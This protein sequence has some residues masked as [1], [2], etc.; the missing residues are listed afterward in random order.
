MT[1][2]DS[3]APRV[4][5][6]YGSGPSNVLLISYLFPPSSGVGSPRALSYTR[7]LPEH[8]CRVVVLT[9]RFATTAYNDVALLDKVPE[10]TIIHRVFNPEVPYA[11]RDRIWKSVAPARLASE[12][13]P[14]AG[15]SPRSFDW[16]RPGK[17][18]I[19]HVFQRVACPDPQVAWSHF[20]TRAALRLVDRYK[21]DTILLNV[22]PYSSMRIAVALK[23]RHPHVKL[24]ADIRDDWVGYYLPLFD[25]AATEHKWKVAKRLERELIE[26]ADYVSAVTPAQVRQIR[27]RYPE[28]SAG[29]F[30][31]TPN[32]YDPDVFRGFQPRPH[33]QDGL[34]VTY[35]GSVY[36]NPVYCPKPYLDAVDALPEEIRSRIETRFI[37]KVHAEAAPILAHRKSRVCQMGYMPQEQGIRHLEES[38]CLLLI[39][40]DPTT[41]AGKLFDYLAT[42]KP[43]FAVTPLDGEIAQIIREAR[44]GWCVDSKDPSA[45]TAGLL[46]V[47]NQVRNRTRDLTPNWE[48]IRSFS[49]PSIVAR[50]AERT[51]L[52]PVTKQIELV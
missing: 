24:I 3:K 30:L 16:L 33:A 26:C 14:A 1:N 18:V 44:T 50:L 49:R 20:A 47:Y 32:G 51:G 5:A 17:E 43:I 7:Y 52:R 13:E 12:L 11:F 4:C 27:E 46:N 31:Y 37:G 29:K 40:N 41:H 2:S 19:R 35:F 25:S 21:I 10:D 8:G 36:G 9:A 28:Q 23:R 39:A 38:D 22:P 48:F 45:I 6:D 34:V 15:C 42:G